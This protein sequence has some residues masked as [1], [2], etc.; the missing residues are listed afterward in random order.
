[1]LSACGAS[2]RC[3]VN[4]KPSDAVGQDERQSL[5]CSAIQSCWM[6]FDPALFAAANADSADRQQEPRAPVASPLPAISLPAAP[7][8]SLSPAASRVFDRKQATDNPPRMNSGLDLSRPVSPRATSNDSRSQSGAA[9]T[10][11]D[12]DA[13]DTASIRQNI[14]NLVHNGQAHP[15]AGGGTTSLAQMMGA[16]GQKRTHRVNTGMTEQ[17]REETERLEREMAATRAKWAAKNPP[18]SNGGAQGPPTGGLSLASLLTGK[19]TTN[20]AATA[21]AVMEPSHDNDAAKSPAESAPTEPARRFAASPEPTTATAASQSEEPSAASSLPPPPPPDQPQSSTRKPHDTL[22]RLQSSNIVSDRLRWSEQIQNRADEPQQEGTP[23]T[24]V[25][26]SPEK[27]RSVL[28]RWGRDEPSAD[29]NAAGG[30]SA[31]PSSPTAVRTRPKSIF[32]APAPSSQ[33]FSALSEKPSDSDKKEDASAAAPK[34]QHVRSVPEGFPFLSFPSL[35]FDR[36]LT[37]SSTFATD[38]ERPRSTHQIDCP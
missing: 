31:V 16:S 15:S 22:T 33:P 25:P 21:P 17:E 30:G 35:P 1:M 8:P 5:S 20:R 28:E 12:D 24:S 19:T 11:N 18:S 6:D 26:P 36:V 38:H 34:L 37:L 7:R 23:T 10:N 13:R 27:R 29:A 14:L 2:E 4:L 3:K 32:D 9:N